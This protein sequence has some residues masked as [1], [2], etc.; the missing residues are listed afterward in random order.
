MGKTNQIKGLGEIPVV[1]RQKN[2]GN[3]SRETT[4]QTH[5]F[6]KIGR[7]TED[8]KGRQPAVFLTQPA[9]DD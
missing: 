7:N 6:P 4:F 3:Q 1:G 2:P 8:N 5:Q 9:P